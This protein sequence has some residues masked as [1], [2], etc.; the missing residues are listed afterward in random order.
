[1]FDRVTNPASDTTGIIHEDLAAAA[2][3]IT[4]GLVAAVLV[5]LAGVGLPF[6]SLTAAA[7]IGFALASAPTMDWRFVPVGLVVGLAGDIL[8]WRLPPGWRSRLI[9][10]VTAGIVVLGSGLAIL[11]TAK[12]AW[13]PTLLSG[14]T[15]AAV[16]AGWGLGAIHGRP[17]PRAPAAP[18]DG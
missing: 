2:L 14:V 18:A 13:T 16:A 1:V 7:V 5:L 11:V 17:A 12:L 6:G 4:A 10:A 8:A 9:G 15:A 3:L